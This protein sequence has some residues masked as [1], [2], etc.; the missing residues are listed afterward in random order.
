[1]ATKGIGLPSI[2]TN[3]GVVAASGVAKTSTDAS[4][5]VVVAKG[6]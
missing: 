2:A 6:G 4:K 5:E 3:E 1:V